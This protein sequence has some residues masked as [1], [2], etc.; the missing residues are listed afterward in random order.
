MRVRCVVCF[1][2]A[3][4]FVPLLAGCSG[5]PRPASDS[6]ALPQSLARSTLTG[7]SIIRTAANSVAQLP[8]RPNVTGRTKPTPF[9]NVAGIESSGRNLIAFSDSDADAV[10]ILGSGGASYAVLT[11]GLSEPQG[12]AFDERGTLYVANTNDSQVLV[13]PK[14]YTNSSLT[15]SDSGQYPAGVAVASDGT[16]GVTNIIST[17][18]GPG[19]VSIYASGATSPCATVKSG[20]LA[21]VYFDAFDKAGNLYVDGTGAD[22]RFVV[23]EVTG[24]C[25]AKSIARLSIRN[26]IVSPGGVAV[27][28]NGAIALGDQANRNGTPSVYTYEPPS[29]GSLG[30]PT[31]TTMLKAAYDAVDFAFDR[32]DR[33]LWIADAGADD[34]AKYL[35]PAGGLPTGAYAN[36]EQPAG[37]AAYPPRS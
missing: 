8:A 25:A 24:E 26:N 11:A 14:P 32:V 4:G 9:V 29:G 34:F 5:G 37:V 12:L 35:Y 20:A 10:F 19:S 16:V 33:N 21:R 6:G 30:S 13:Y 36:F 1:I 3:A 2:S 17:S 23:G 27:L 15:L 31:K 7:Q 22:G 28:E 18:D